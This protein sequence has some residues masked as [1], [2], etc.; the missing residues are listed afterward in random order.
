MQAHA[1]TLAANGGEAVKA[2]DPAAATALLKALG[3]EPEVICAGIYTTPGGLLG[4]FARDAGAGAPG[5]ASLP[6]MPPPP[7]TWFA[8]GIRKDG[9]VE[10]VQPIRRDGKQV[11][12]VYI[13]AGFREINQRLQ[14]YLMIFAA[15][16]VGGSL[17]AYAL[18]NRLEPHISRPILD[19]T[20]V[21]RAVTVERNYRLRAE[22][23]NDDEMGELVDCF[24][25]MLEQ[26]RQRDT[27]LQGHRDK[28]EEQIKQRTHQLSVLNAQLAAEKDK[29]ELAN[30]AKSAFLANM[31]HEIRTPMAAILGYTDMMADPNQTPE[32]RANCLGVVR[33]N[34]RHLLELINDI[35]DLS[36]IEADKMTVESIP[37]DL[38]Q[39][40]SEVVSLMRPRALEKKLKFE[41]EFEGAIPRVVMTDPLRLRQVLINLIGNAIK[42]TPAGDVKLRVACEKGARRDGEEAA[43]CAT[44]RFDVADTGIGM[45]EEQVEKLFQPFTQADDSTTRKFGGTGLGLTISRRL[46]K[47][48]GGDITVNSRRGLGSTFTLRIPAVCVEGTEMVS[49]LSEAMLSEAPKAAAGPI[50]IGGRILLAEDGVD[51]QELIK[52][53]VQSAGASVVVAENGRAAIKRFQAQP[54]GEAFDLV[55]M[56][57]QMPVMDGYEAAGELRKQGHKV[58]I[59]ALTAHAMPED[60]AKCI[61]AGCTDYLVKPVDREVLLKTLAKYLPAAPAPGA[62]PVA[63]SVPQPEPVPIAPP[64]AAPVEP[65]VPA[66]APAAMKDLLA[67]YIGRLPARV[68]EI[69]R[70]MDERD[71]AQLARA[72]HQIKG[73]AGGYGFPTIGR[74]AE[75]AE[76]KLRGLKP[77]DRS[78]EALEAITTEVAALVES[79][80]AVAGYDRTR[81]PAV[82]QPTGMITPG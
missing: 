53:H 26:I 81:E 47:L 71:L 13:R 24:N 45:T 58:P 37:T 31:S 40:M 65:R 82:E 10:T 1:Q 48:L 77:D 21:A 72:V 42:F 25:Q 32:Q 16:V 6:V 15:V 2:N 18:V 5:G 51:N 12:L 46:G 78:H 62:Q 27:Q 41:L 8:D 11:G 80:R 36:K 59:V 67:R 17:L 35:L 60:R 57:M 69:Q 66:G 30:R 23:R 63:A 19:L 73:S 44:L 43:A 76:R 14:T 4:T 68:A 3:V 70:L 56:D 22:K 79:I 28:L 34:G 9:Y 55:L 54:S 33:R 75:S 64:A 74:A 7:G 29:A 49:G 61:A 50:T 20:R 52:A 38:P 39:V